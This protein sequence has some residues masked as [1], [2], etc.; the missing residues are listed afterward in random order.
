MYI[1]EPCHTP[2]QLSCFKIFG[3]QCVF[4]KLPSLWNDIDLDLPTVF[5]E[6]SLEIKS[7]KMGA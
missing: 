2:S 6:L 7:V 4:R 3:V 5:L 1:Q